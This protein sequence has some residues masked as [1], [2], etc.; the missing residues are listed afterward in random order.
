MKKRVILVIQ[1]NSYE[2]GRVEDE[3]WKGKKGGREGNTEGGGEIGSGCR[4]RCESVP[5]VVCNR[6]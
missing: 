5:Q 2:L 1:K 4:E 3:L 6:G